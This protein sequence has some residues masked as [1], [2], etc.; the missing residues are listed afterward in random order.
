MKAILAR[1]HSTSIG[2]VRRPRRAA[3]DLNAAARPPSPKHLA[4][5]QK[6]RGRK[7]WVNKSARDIYLESNPDV[8]FNLMPCKWEGCKAELQNLDTLRRHVEAVHRQDDQ[9]GQRQ[10]GD[11]ES[12]ESQ[13]GHERWFVCRW[14]RCASDAS[15]RDRKMTADQWDEHM[16][17]EHLV[18]YSWHVGDGISNSSSTRKYAKDVDSNI[19]PDWL[20]DGQG[21]QV[22]PDA[23]K[24]D[25]EDAVTAQARARKLE[26]LRERVWDALPDEEEYD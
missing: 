11:G 10:H 23:R 24:V 7:A 14:S 21:R 19:I 2:T 26:A 5:K 12:P 17:Q 22:T 20:C 8:D 6:K 4:S 18:P 3:Q 1:H 13:A 25:I 9:L 15:K 16:E